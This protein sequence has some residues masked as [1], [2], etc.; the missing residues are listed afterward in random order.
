MQSHS[1]T[2][3]LFWLDFLCENLA[4]PCN[5][6]PWAVEAGITVLEQPFHAVG[7]LATAG[8]CLASQYLAGWAIIRAAGRRHAEEVLHYV[9][10]PGSGC[11]F[12]RKRPG[13]SVQTAHHFGDFAHRPHGAGGRAAS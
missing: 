7:N 10:P 13:V 8:G 4:Y 1:Q 6:P 3:M 5:T 9:A 12:R 2:N 11:V